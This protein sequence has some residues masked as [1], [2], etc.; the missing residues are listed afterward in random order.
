M[1]GILIEVV[2]A[3][4]SRH[5]IEKYFVKDRDDGKLLI[6]NRILYKDRYKDS[7]DSELIAWAKANS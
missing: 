5:E 1:A 7:Y 3:W 2:G 6:R 4:D